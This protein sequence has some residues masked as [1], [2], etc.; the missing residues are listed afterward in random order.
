MNI[1]DYLLPRWKSSNPETRIRAIRE[2]DDGAADVLMRIVVEDSEPA[3]RLEALGR[4][5]DRESLHSIVSNSSDM[6][7]I[8][9]AWNKL[10]TMYREMVFDLELDR[11]T[12]TS[13]LGKINGDEILASIAGE[14]DDPDIRVAAIERIFNPTILC[15]IAESNC[16]LKAGLAIV[17]KLEGEEFLERVAKTASNKRVRKTAEDKRAAI[18]E[19]KNRPS[20]EKMFEMRMEELCAGLENVKDITDLEKSSDFLEKASEE[21]RQS[22]PESIHPLRQ[23]FD[24]ALAKAEEIVELT[25]KNRMALASFRELCESLEELAGTFPSDAR[26]RTE[27]AKNDWR[28]AEAYF[29]NKADPVFRHLESRFTGLCDELG[30]KLEKRLEELENRESRIR[31]MEDYCVR[32]EDIAETANIGEAWENTLETWE[33]VKQGWDHVYFDTPETAAFTKRYEAA[34][35]KLRNRRGEFEERTRLEKQKQ[36]ARLIEL[37]E[38]VENAIDKEDRA[39]LDRDVRAIQQEW[40]EAGG[41]AADAKRELAPRFQ[42]ACG[43]FFEKQAEYWELLDWE[44]WANLNQKSELCEI[45]ETVAAKEE[46]ENAA[47]VVRECQNKWKGIGPVSKEKSDEIWNRFKSSCDSAYQRCLEAKTGLLGQ[48]KALAG[49][50]ENTVNWK[51]TAAKIK[52]IQEQWNKIGFLP[53]FMEKD[54]RD[55]FRAVCN[56]FFE[57]QRNFYS[58]LDSERQNNLKIK[59][60][61]CEEAE[62]LADSDDWSKTAGRLKEL[63][64]MW[65]EVGPIPKKEGDVIWRRFRAACNTFFDRMKSR[66]PENLKKKEALCER[67][68]AVLASVND[69]TD[70][71]QVSKTLIEIQKEWKTIGPVPEEMADEIWNRFRTPCDE[72]FSKR[73]EWLNVIKEEKTLHREAKEALVIE[74]VELSESTDWK[75]AGDRLKELQRIWQDVGSAPRKNERE[76][77][78]RFRGAC[79]TFFNRRNR[80]FEKMDREREDNL[81][82][83]KTLCLS[84]E[85]L[86]RLVLP[87]KVKEADNPDRAAEQLSMALDMK[88]EIVVPGDNKATWDRAMNKVK[89][90]QAEWKNI[91][92]VPQ[93]QGQD[94][95]KRFRR[96]ADPFYAP[97]ENRSS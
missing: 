28:H 26:T 51:E 16:G 3:V 41:L 57:R 88:N 37:C 82:K 39:G 92:P 34:G 10:N 5:G 15:K 77:W 63:Q 38:I 8:K 22:D 95:W 40:K 84:L 1:T 29:D 27:K 60:E 66:K 61:F 96:A 73:K 76:L 6:E 48:A 50:D 46:L 91:G 78:L 18:I 97:R 11:E 54:I 20:P 47:T 85:V 24:I 59:T 74:A 33:S 72:F 42:Q 35:E 94:L 71:E 80:H 86:A 55:S 4:I 89:K 36:E 53:H 75:T 52:Q 23:R 49:A 93:K 62:V 31:E 56:D 14:I 79:D 9:A 87:E 17:F 81:E 19:E 67:V 64:R 45:V 69:D 90:I 65:R 58:Q 70:M 2:M 25:R 13:V 43:K 12:R 44:R 7:I 32:F 83:K 30:M 21:V 68:E